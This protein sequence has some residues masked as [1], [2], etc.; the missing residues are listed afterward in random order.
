MRQVI[1]MMLLVLLAA[2]TTAA[3]RATRNRNL[4]TT[5]EITSLHVS[6]AYEVVAMLRPQYLRTR[7]SASINDPTPIPAVVYLDGFKHGNT[8]DAL[9]T[10]DRVVI[11]EIEYL[12]SREATTRF[13]TGH[14]GGAILVRTR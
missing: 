10:I 5:E 1:S 13:G 4:I 9:K 12:D 8:P 14:R 11:R 6:T 2:C 3:P 7:G